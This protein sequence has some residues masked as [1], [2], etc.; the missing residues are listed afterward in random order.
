MYMHPTR[1]K[2]WY[3]KSQEQVSE[4]LIE[5]KEYHSKSTS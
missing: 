1:L 3:E 2:K 5:L 4:N